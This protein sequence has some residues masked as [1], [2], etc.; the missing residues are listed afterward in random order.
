MYLYYMPYKIVLTAVN[1]ASCYYALFKYA[2][3]FAKR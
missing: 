3:Y 2:K 1:V